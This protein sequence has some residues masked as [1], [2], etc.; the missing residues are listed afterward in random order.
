MPELDENI[1]R[2]FSEYTN[3]LFAPED[4][5]LAEL[6]RRTAASDQAGWQVSAEV[7][8]L[9][10]LLA[11]TIGARRI[12]ELGTLFGYSAIWLGRALP[13][14]GRLLT[15]EADADRA[16]E[17]REWIA[18]AGLERVVEIRVGPA[19][20]LLP[21]LPAQPLFDLVFIDAAKSEYPAYLDWALEH[22]RDGGLIVADNT[23][24]SGSLEDTVLDEDSPLPGIRAV[25]EFNR[26]IATDPRLSSILLPV[27]EGVS[28][29]LVRR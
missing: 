21:E 26:R 20:S 18:R 7:G 13:S 15:L 29:S 2:R 16:A 14:D 10:H 25:R 1:R 28:V 5:V 22:T 23:L 11:L 8:K 6:G 24:F 9:L 27:R 4:S 17:A 3:A 19:L 12:L